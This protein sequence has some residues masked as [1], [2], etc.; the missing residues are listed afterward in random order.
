MLASSFTVSPSGPIG[1]GS[2]I[3]GSSSVANTVTLTNSGT[4]AIML[5]SIAIAGVN[6]P[7]FVVASNSCSASVPVGG[8]APCRLSS[9][10]L[11][12]AF[13]EQG[14]WSLTARRIQF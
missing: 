6:A 12:Q 7:D 9:S 13:A 14:W 3:I 10:P 8:V 2:V 11:P 5:T 4:T 1:F